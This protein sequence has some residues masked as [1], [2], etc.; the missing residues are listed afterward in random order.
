MQLNLEPLKDKK[1]LLAFSHGVDST[2]LFYLLVK[3]GV[4]FDCAMVNY[5][6]RPSSNTEEQSALIKKYL[7]IKLI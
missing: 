6:T 3:A 5:Q 2:A 7:F 1:A 4:S